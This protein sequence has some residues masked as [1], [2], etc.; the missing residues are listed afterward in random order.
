MI[1]MAT[2]YV[3]PKRKEELFLM[4][5]TVIWLLSDARLTHI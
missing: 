4:S 3:D 2:P 5:L 1:D